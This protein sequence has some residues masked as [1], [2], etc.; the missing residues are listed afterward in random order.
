MNSLFNPLRVGMSTSTLAGI[1]ESSDRIVW[2]LRVEVWF[3]DVSIT[4]GPN[5]LPVLNSFSNLSEVL[6]IHWQDNSFQTTWGCQAAYAGKPFA[7][8]FRITISCIVNRL[9][10]GF[11]NWHRE[12]VVRASIRSLSQSG[13]PGSV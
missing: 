4:S 5:Y 8:H 1:R 3:L 7:C 12:N 11:E 2:T 9:A 13:K 6:G 10:T